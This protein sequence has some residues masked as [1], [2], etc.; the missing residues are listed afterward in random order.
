MRAAV[1]AAV[2]ACGLATGARAAPVTY[3]LVNPVYNG[4]AIGAG[5][6]LNFSL[7][8]SDAAVAVGSFSLTGQGDATGISPTFSGDVA[9]FIQFAA[10]EQATPTHLTGKLSIS[11]TF[12]AG[13]AIAASSFVYGGLNEMSSLSGSN[14]SFGGT[15]GS[16][17]YH[18]LC[19][20]DACAV[21]GQLM[22]SATTSPVPE[23]ISMT[24]FGSG[25]AALGL[26]RRLN[27]PAAVGQV[28]V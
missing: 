3:S 19:G 4:L 16:D 9:D 13:G 1:L 15:F 25:L 6:S 5:A 27:R 10:N 24:L 17:N 8:I 26:L 12:G 22:A 20:S 18:G 11:A 23:P 7:T 14:A 2:M 21:T 28:N